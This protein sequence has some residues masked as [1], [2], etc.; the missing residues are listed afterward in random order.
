MTLPPYST[1]PQ[2]REAQQVEDEQAYQDAIEEQD[3]VPVSLFDQFGGYYSARLDGVEVARFA[4][5]PHWSNYV[6]FA[7]GLQGWSY[8]WIPK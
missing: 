5:S 4:P 2:T 8:V 6:E 3:P 1:D 7:D